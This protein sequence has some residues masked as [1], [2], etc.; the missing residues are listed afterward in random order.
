MANADIYVLLR[1]CVEVNHRCPSSTGHDR[2]AE[3]ALKASGKQGLLQLQRANELELINSD[4]REE[5]VEGVNAASSVGQAIVGDQKGR[6][7]NPIDVPVL[8]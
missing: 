1:I 6:L 4:R 3:A 7:V 8:G 5:L 2:A